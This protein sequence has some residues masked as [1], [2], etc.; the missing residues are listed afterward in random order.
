MVGTETTLILEDYIYPFGA[1]FRRIMATSQL[2]EPARISL[3]RGL[4]GT[5]PSM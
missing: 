5:R 2:R 4:E 1:V 3:L